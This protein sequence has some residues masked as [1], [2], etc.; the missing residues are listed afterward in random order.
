MDQK[1]PLVSYIV[2]TYWANLEYLNQCLESIRKQTY[3][4]IE[5]ILSIDAK[6]AHSKWTLKKLSDY[7]CTLPTTWDNI[8]QEVVINHEAKWAASTRNHAIKNAQGELIA[9]L[10]DDDTIVPEKTALQV[11]YF[12]ENPWTQLVGSWYKRMDEYGETIY[13]KKLFTDGD[14]IKDN[15]LSTFPFLPSTCLIDKNLFEKTWYFDNSLK[16]SED[17][18]FFY[19]AILACTWS[20]LHNIPEYLTNYRVHGASISNVQRMKQRVE[21]YKLVYK[22]GLLRYG[23]YS[24]QLLKVLS[25]H[26]LKFFF[27]HPKIKPTAL[28]FHDTIKWMLVR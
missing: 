28:R 27:A 11:A 3:R 6:A 19:R 7:C 21:G 23:R 20:Q 12:Q 13:N 26:A 25:I 14:D 16:T 22:Y 18:D 5:I 24:P 4:N 1:N 8:L 9:L 17:G 15:F 10:D 2:P